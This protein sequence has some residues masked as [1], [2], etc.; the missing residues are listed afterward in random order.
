MTKNQALWEKLDRFEIGDPDAAFSF[1]HRLARENG[2]SS[3][4]ALRAIGEYKK[5][6]YL[7]AS[8]AQ[9]RT[10]SNAVDQVWHLHLTYS[11]SYWDEMC[12]GLLGRRIHHGPAKG[13]GA[14]H[15]KFESAYRDTLDAYR[16]EFGEPPADIWPTADIRFAPARLRWVDQRTHW[17]LP[18]IGFRRLSAVVVGAAIL[19]AASDAVHAASAKAK[20]T[21]LLTVIGVT[22]AVLAVVSILG[23]MISNDVAQ[24]SRKK[25]NGGCTGYVP[26]GCGGGGKGGGK[27]GGGDAGCGGSGCGGGGGCGGS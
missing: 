6:I 5:F 14:E 8:G 15:A 7:I 11:Q 24:A 9:M 12:E 17:V 18:K 2:W 10:P 16:A 27:D 19:F 23:A 4:Q 25:E 21:D 22:A 26:F 13:G 1:A 3:E 20:E